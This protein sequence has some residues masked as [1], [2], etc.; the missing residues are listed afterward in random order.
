[1]LRTEAP[2]KW[3]DIYP[4][5][6]TSQIS[7]EECTSEALYNDE[8]KYVFKK[9]WLFAAHR[10]DLAK[11]GDY[12]VKE[13]PATKSSILLCHQKDGTIQGFHNVC[14][15][16]L[17]K[18]LPSDGRGCLNRFTC[19]FHGWTYNTSGDLIGMPDPDGILVKESLGLIKVPTAVWN[20]FVFICLDPNP[21]QSF[22]DYLGGIGSH[23][24]NQFPFGNEWDSWGWRIEVK[25]NWKI[26]KDLFS[27]TYHVAFVHKNSVHKMYSAPSN[28][29]LHLPV[30]DFFG[31]HYKF[32]GP[33]S[34]EPADAAGPIGALSVKYGGSKS[35]RYGKARDALPGVNPEGLSNW[36]LD[37]YGIFPNFNVNIFG[38]LWHYHLFEPLGVDRCAWENR[39]FFP[40]AQNAGERFAH[41]YAQSLQLALGSEDMSAA[42]RNQSGMETGG[43]PE[44][45]LHDQEIALRFIHKGVIDYVAQNK[46]REA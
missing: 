41:E 37:S 32:T 39:I 17:A 15:H 2:K 19:E 5:L 33:A 27:E 23:P 31:P 34:E 10:L 7:S 38:S 26:V 4:Q 42:E 8:I 14:R 30:V 9:A 21:Q 40:K 45:A 28:P 36:A 43:V 22:K 25:A 29:F 46:G 3:S 1:M 20:G 12:I 13:F 16:R 44:Y 6:A 11:P 18:L 24:V 35:S